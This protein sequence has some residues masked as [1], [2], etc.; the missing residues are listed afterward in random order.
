MVSPLEPSVSVRFDLPRKVGKIMIVNTMDGLRVEAEGRSSLVI[1]ESQAKILREL[2]DASEGLIATELSKRLGMTHSGILFLLKPLQSAGL[3]ERVT[4][5]GGG[6]LYYTK[7]RIAQRLSPE[8]A[9]VKN[10]LEKKR[11]KLIELFELQELYEETKG[12]P[13]ETRKALLNWVLDGGWNN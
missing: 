4:L 11:G 13:P 2:D 5:R 9:E 6:V 1:N 7:A 10:G 3:V 8:L 12:L